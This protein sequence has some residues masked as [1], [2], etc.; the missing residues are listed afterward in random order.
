[1]KLKPEFFNI[2]HKIKGYTFYES[3]SNEHNRVYVPRTEDF[4]EFL[5]ALWK[6]VPKKKKDEKAKHNYELF[7]KYPWLFV[8]NRWD[9][10]VPLWDSKYKL[11]PVWF[12]WHEA[13]ALERAN[14]EL[15]MRM[16]EELAA[17]LKEKAP[18][19]YYYYMIV[20]IK[21]KYGTLRWYDN[22]NT[23]KG[24]AIVNKYCKLFEKEFGWDQV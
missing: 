1:M 13:D 15:F 2:E 20:D 8:K 5:D 3:D 23:E 14:E 21:E 4:L 6:L 18:N 16:Q 24:R 10:G 12:E 17:E 19:S 22:G 11:D 7:K 9:G